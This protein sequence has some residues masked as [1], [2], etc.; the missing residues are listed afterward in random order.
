MDFTCYFYCAIGISKCLD[1][2]RDNQPLDSSQ[3]SVMR[4]FGDDLRTDCWPQ[5]HD[6]ATRRS[7]LLLNADK[8]DKVLPTPNPIQPNSSQIKKNIHHAA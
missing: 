4:T 8:K 6:D 3:V 5:H 1:S 7:N 2:F